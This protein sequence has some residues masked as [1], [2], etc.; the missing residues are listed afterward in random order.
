MGKYNSRKNNKSRS[1]RVSRKRTSKKKISKQRR[2]NIVRL[3][4]LPLMLNVIGGNKV[5]KEECKK[6][7]SQPN[8][9]Y[10]V[11]PKQKDYGSCTKTCET[12]NF[13]NGFNYPAGKGCDTL[14]S[15]TPAAK[16]VAKPVSKEECKKC[17]SQPNMRYCVDPKQKDYGS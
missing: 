10:C 1:K 11:D 8:M 2:N 17:I 15:S 7:I 13:R 5:S 4:T 14:Q 16:P 9:R 3:M 6:C 12:S